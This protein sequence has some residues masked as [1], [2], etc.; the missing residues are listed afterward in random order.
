MCWPKTFR[1]IIE[2]CLG[3]RTPLV[4]SFIDYEQAFNSADRR[5]LTKVLFLYAIVIN[6]N[7]DEWLML[8]ARI[9]LLQLR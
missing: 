3:L 5:A 1:L 4:V 7:S 6:G 9:T 2:K 8:Y